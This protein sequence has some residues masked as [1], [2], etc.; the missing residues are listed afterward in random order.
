MERINLDH[1]QLALREISKLDLLHRHR[2]ASAPVERLID[3]AERSFAD[4]IAESLF[5]S[6]QEDISQLF[7]FSKPLEGEHGP[8][9]PSGQRAFPLAGQPFHQGPQGIMPAM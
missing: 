1:A 8:R 9:H 3:G 7:L 6:S 5:W 4:A 2:L